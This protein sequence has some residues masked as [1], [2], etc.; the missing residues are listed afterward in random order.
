MALSTLGLTD[1]VQV[2]GK[3][4]EGKAKSYTVVPTGIKSKGIFSAVPGRPG[5]SARP[6]IV[7]LR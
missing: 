5:L 2:D 7:L 4:C 3:K 6:S 1:S